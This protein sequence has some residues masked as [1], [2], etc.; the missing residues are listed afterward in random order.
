MCKK[1]KLI[2]E[3]SQSLQ[4]ENIDEIK[5]ENGEVTEKEKVKIEDAKSEKGKQNELSKKEVIVKN[6]KTMSIQILT[7]MLG[8]F[9]MAL[10][11]QIF[12][13]PHNIVPGGFM[14]L[15]KIVHDVIAKTGF[16][17]ISTYAW[18]IILNVF[19]YIYAVKCLGWK[20][21]IRAGVGI[22]SFAIFGMIIENTNLVGNITEMIKAEEATSYILYAIYGGVLMGAGLGLVFRGNGSTGGCDMV[23]L[24]VNKFFPTITTGQIIMFVD[25][26]VVV[27]S[28]IAYGSLVL[29][30][31]ALIT[32]FLSG[33]VSD[34]FV[35]GIRSLRAYYVVTDKKEEISQAVFEKLNRGVT[36][37]KC[38]GMFTHNDKDMLLI[39]VRRAQIL[40]LKKIV[41][42]IDPNSFMFSHNVK[43]AYGNGFI[44]YS[45]DNK[46]K[47]KNKLQKN[48]AE[49]L[50]TTTN[51]NTNS[52]E[53]VNTSKQVVEQQENKAVTKVKEN[54]K[55]TTKTKNN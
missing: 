44:S 7:I 3:T 37:L 53:N 20:F 8:T 10:S 36:N 21:G 1:G 15:A 49:N 24:V 26:A 17:Y 39:I 5:V 50:S 6:I 11:F 18:Y 13:T 2:V 12:L 43:E 46:T 28:V 38:E 35:D 47:R 48:D 16:T 25:G 9:V 19:L 4:Q 32:I 23:A 27:L 40:T 42:R 29:P 54:K 45:V 34:M 31:Y 14:G 51:V 52:N 41:K 30:L 22:F 33:K 55:P